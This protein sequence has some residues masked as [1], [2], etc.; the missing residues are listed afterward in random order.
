MFRQRD[1]GAISSKEDRFF[2]IRMAFQISYLQ[3]EVGD[4]SN[5]FA[6]LTTVTH[7]LAAAKVL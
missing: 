6:F 5:I 1:I 7:N 4:P 2:K 3:N